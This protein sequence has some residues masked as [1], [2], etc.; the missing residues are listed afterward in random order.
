[1][2]EVVVE[3]QSGVIEVRE[4]FGDIQGS[5]SSDNSEEFKDSIENRMIRQALTKS[6]YDQLKSKIS[7]SVH[8]PQKN[9]MIK[10]L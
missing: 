10:K 4:D 2:Y 5:D 3:D 1:M 7:P 6:N 9:K 8:V